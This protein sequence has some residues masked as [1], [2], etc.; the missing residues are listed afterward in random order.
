MDYLNSFFQNI[1]D[2]L[3]NPFFG[4]LILI[5][6][7]HHWELWYSLFNFDKNY[8]RNAKVLLIK[9][10]AEYELT[11][12]NI[13]Y[14]IFYAIIIFLCGYFI[15]VGTRTLSMLIEFRIMPFITGKII[16]KNVVLKSTHDETV[17]ERDEYS[18]KYEEQRKNVRL[19]SK[20]YDE[21][22]EQIK[23][24]DIELADTMASVSSL[25][26]KLNSSERKV[27]NTQN[28][29]EKS[30]I[31]LQ[32]LEL[33]TENQKN[34]SEFFLDNLQEY[35]SLFFNEENLLFWNS[36]NKFPT[37]IINKVIE[38]KKANKWKQ[39]LEV[40][41]YLENGGTISPNRINEI[42]EFEII[43]QIKGKKFRQL[44]PIGGIISKYR[45]ILD[46][47]ETDYAIF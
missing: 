25:T 12:K 38:L 47:V 39:F 31:K 10:L 43:K 35:S 36:P 28:E 14:D 27:E 3:S 18:E 42:E 1:K 19:L 4:T 45:S 33:E 46:K 17:L 41:N 21:Q 9:N 34:E 20:N 26:K 8:T 15:I 6:I 2:K 16:N 11:T 5:I 32:Q 30:K 29:L 40:A 13:T 23:T 24:K 7:I 22:I 37:I 44:S